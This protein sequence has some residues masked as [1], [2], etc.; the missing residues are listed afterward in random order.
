MPKYCT[1]YIAYG[2]LNAS[3][4]HADAKET[5]QTSNHQTTLYPLVCKPHPALRMCK[6]RQPCST[7]NTF[8]Q[9]L[10]RTQ[11]GRLTASINDP[12]TIG[13]MAPTPIHTNFGTLPGPVR[14]AGITSR[15]G[16]W[17]GGSSSWLERA[18]V[19]RDDYYGSKRTCN[20]CI[21]C[22]SRSCSQLISMF[23]SVA[24]CSYLSWETLY[25]ELLLVG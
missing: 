7:K 21:K 12:W 18:S 17:V 14:V 4:S 8:L 22:Q 13:W 1:P 19:W 11:V 20:S 23:S 24:R 25:R 16:R 5:R 2:I 3:K 6:T 15:V 10:G 9:A